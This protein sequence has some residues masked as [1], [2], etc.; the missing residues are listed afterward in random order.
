MAD[1]S[2]TAHMPTILVDLTTLA[3]CLC[4]TGLYNHAKA[5]GINLGTVGFTSPYKEQVALLKHELCTELNFADE[6][7]LQEAGLRV[8]TVDG[9]QGQEA[10]IILYSA[11]R[12]NHTGAVGFT[13]DKRRLNVALTRAKRSLWVFGSVKTL[14]NHGQWRRFIRHARRKGCLRQVHVA[15]NAAP[16][17]AARAGADQQRPHEQHMR[18][19]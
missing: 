17:A 11:V 15:D 1:C 6:A 12:A 10:D 14:R 4:L 19:K 2:S 18:R 9:F 16:G 8:G 3:C 13:G 7:A 5:T